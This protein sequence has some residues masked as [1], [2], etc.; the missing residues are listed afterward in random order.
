MRDD[1][2]LSS[3]DAVATQSAAT[4]FLGL[5][6]NLW[7]LSIILAISQFS[8]AIWKWQFGIYIETIIEPW[9][10]GITFSVGTF[11]A[12]VGSFVIGALTDFVGRRW[13]LVIGFVPI[14]VGLLSL[15][16]LPIWPLIPVQFGLIW[17]GLASA[18]IMSRAIPADEIEASGGKSPAR[19]IMM[20]MMPVFFVDGFGPIIG[21]YLLSIGYVPADLHRLASLG[22]IAAIIA[23]I[24]L[25]KESLGEEV[26]QK[27]RAGAKLSARQLGSDFWKLAAGMIAF[28]F[29]WAMAIQYLGNLSVNDWNVDTVTYG[30][31]WSA[32][33]LFGALIMYPASILADR[34]LKVALFAAVAGN[35]VIFILFA[36]GT[37][38]PMMYLVN[39][40]WAPPFMV[41]VG[42]ERSIVVVTVP[43]EAKGRALGTYQSLMSGI[44]IIAAMVGAVL[45][46]LNGSLRFVWGLA[47]IAMLANLVI[48]GLALRSIKLKREP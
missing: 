13:T 16:F 35:G 27:A 42:A 9:Q 26:I 43:E 29:F 40:L 31:T 46:E 5:S 28:S 41:F 25:F 37:G 11:S 44:A 32:F 19:K 36:I 2:F 4:G 30:L 24:V 39:L 8:I 48:L 7:N 6:R 38:V 14:F 15:S 10:M 21:S 12:L 23:A 18:R 20:V 17:Y 1:S 22:S 47:G 33:S 3:T 45:W 34:N